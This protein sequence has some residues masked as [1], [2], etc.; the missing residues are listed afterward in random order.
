M[1]MRFIS[2]EV[3]KTNRNKIRKI[4]IILLKLVYDTIDLAFF[5]IWS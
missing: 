1:S 2:K 4:V 5:G 3:N